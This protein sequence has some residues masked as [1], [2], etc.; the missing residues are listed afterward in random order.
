[1]L[2]KYLNKIILG[3]SY[4]LIKD[5]PDKSIDLIVTDPPYLIENTKAGGGATYPNLYKE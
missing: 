2:D 1:M 5:L 4:E 3:N